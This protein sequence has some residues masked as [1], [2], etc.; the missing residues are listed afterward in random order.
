MRVRRPI[1]AANSNSRTALYVV[2]AAAAFFVQGCTLPRKPVP[3]AR[4]SDG[5]ITGFPNVR[6][7]EIEYAPDVSF[8]SADSADCS[9]LVLSG[10]GSKGAFGA[11]FLNGWTVMGTRPQFKLVTGISTG[12]LIAPLAFLGSEYDAQLKDSYTT[13]TTKDILNL[14]G[15]LNFGILAVLTGESAASSEPLENMI[16]QMV[17]PEVLQAVAAEHRKGRR[18]YIGTTNLD[19]QRLVAWDMGAIAQSNRPE[20]I[21]LFRKVMLASASIPGAFPPVHFTVEV[22]GKEYD[23]M[24]VD[25]G[26]IAGLFGYGF[27]LFDDSNAPSSCSIYIIKN[28]KLDIESTQVKRHFFP[29]VGR[30]IDTLMKSQSWGDMIRLR[31]RAL[32]DRV[33]FHYIS[34]PFEFVSKGEEMFDAEEMRR[35]YDMGYRIAISEH[36]WRTEIPFLRGEREWLWTSENESG[37]PPNLPEP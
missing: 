28:G 34:I 26:I 35:M 25:G 24:H 32:Q 30:T 17:T 22:D 2:L 29:I 31:N 15:L 9:F 19:A 12:A 33:A 20:A 36:P 10:G 13:V 14:K 5:K 18:L 37:D 1:F 6:F 21:N 7:W 23:E 4:I 3:V 8:D 11:G 16:E 27:A